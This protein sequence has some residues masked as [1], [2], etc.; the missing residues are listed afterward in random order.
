MSEAHPAP[1]RR[2]LI[3]IFLLIAAVMNQVDITIANVAL[4][5]MQGSTSAS[6][7]QIACFTSASV[8]CGLAASLE[9]LILFRMLQ[10][11]TGAALVPVSQATMLDSFP[12][13]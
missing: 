7:E 3:T 1:A 4:P 5:H 11:M 12:T 10:G 8:L 6:R 13:E 9:Q 2:G